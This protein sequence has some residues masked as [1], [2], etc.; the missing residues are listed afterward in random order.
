M[1]VFDALGR[2]QHTLVDEVMQAGRYS[3]DFHAAGLASGTYFY[4][5]EA[6]GFTSTR[7][8]LLLK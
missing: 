3:V 5:I 1:R 6:P 2:V 8:L 7:K 4:R